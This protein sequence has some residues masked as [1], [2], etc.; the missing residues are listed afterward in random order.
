MTEGN[1]YA[2]E[3]AVRYYQRLLAEGGH[4]GRLPDYD[5]IGR[6]MA[7][8]DKSGDVVHIQL[9]G[10]PDGIETARWLCGRCD[11][12]IQ[13]AADLVC[14][15]AE[16]D[17]CHAWKRIDG[18]QVQTLL[19]GP[20]ADV[21]SHAGAAVLTLFKA[22]VDLR[23]RHAL[24]GQVGRRVDENAPLCSAS[25]LTGDSLPAL[26][27]RALTEYDLRL[28]R[29]K[30]E[31]WSQGGTVRDLTEYVQSRL[32]GEA[33]RIIRENQLGFPHAMEV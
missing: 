17:D 24:S 31:E 9:R 7:C 27:S 21:R 2:D 25:E 22:V 11:P 8:P 6:V 4:S 26:V 33:V 3:I 32:E 14:R 28:P 18:Q 19:G 13:I 12:W 23:L 15:L 16:G 1:V 20:S 10:T 5:G 30:L 29:L